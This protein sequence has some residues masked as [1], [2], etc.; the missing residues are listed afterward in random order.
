VEE[1]SDLRAV[2]MRCRPDWDI[3][4]AGATSRVGEGRQGEFFGRKNA[5]VTLAEQD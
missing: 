5:R 2:L 4:G 3:S 1:L